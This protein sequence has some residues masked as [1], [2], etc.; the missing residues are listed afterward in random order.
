MYDRLSVCVN[1]EGA[2]SGT[3]ATSVRRVGSL[4]LNHDRLRYKLAILSATHPHFGREHTPIDPLS[5]LGA[6]MVV[7]RYTCAP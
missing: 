1:L 7:P 5:H 4:A 3:L 2:P 6:Y